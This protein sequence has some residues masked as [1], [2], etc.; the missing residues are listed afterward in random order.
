[1]N[2]SKKTLLSVI[3]FLLVALI[4]TGVV[5]KVK[6]DREVEALRIY[7]ETYL[8]MDGVEYLRASTELDLSGVQL[9]E[10]EKLAELENLS[11]LDLRNTGISAQQYDVLRAAL[12][13]CE[14]LWSVPFQGGY[15]E[16]TVKKLATSRILVTTNHPRARFRTSSSVRRSFAF[17][18]R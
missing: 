10:A 12:P 6:H 2:K 13:Q 7:N 18:A 11:K 8:V 5:L 16:N 4:A 15:C 14:I 9:T 3:A 1:M 17:A